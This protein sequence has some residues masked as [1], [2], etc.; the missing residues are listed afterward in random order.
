VFIG[1]KPPTGGGIKI[2]KGNRN[3]RKMGRKRKKEEERGKTQVKI[4]D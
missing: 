3:R 1:E 4:E 2:N